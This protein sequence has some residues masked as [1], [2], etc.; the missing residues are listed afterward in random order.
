MSHN[1]LVVLPL[2]EHQRAEFAAALPDAHFTFMAAKDVTPTDVAGSDVILGNVNP[3]FIGASPR[4]KWIHLG[5][6][7]ADNYVVPGVLD[8]A[9]LLTSSVGAYG[10]AVSEH[11]FAQVLA[12]QKKLELYRDDQRAH[13]WTDEGTVSSLR[14][15]TVLVLGAG[16]IGTAF[17]RLCAAFG[18]HVVG[19]R[20]HPLE[21][22]EP[23][24]RIVS[25]DEARALLPQAD[26]VVSFL[27]STPQT[28]SFAN[29]DFFAAMKEGAV[30]ANGGRGDFVDEDALVAALKSGHLAGAAL[31]V[32]RTEPLPTDSPLWDVPNLLITPHVAGFFHLPANLDATVDLTLDNLRRY[33]AGEPLPRLIAH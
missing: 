11:V 32:M 18:A 5:S 30:F 8:P 6:A 13:S 2:T 33:A 27:P 22:G 15:A 20:R 29:A 23:Y 25:L 14:G 28:Q 31:D 4:L 17:A 7:G 1:V 3:A 24:E 10:Q 21:P 9:T 26:V 12:V 16:D 19:A